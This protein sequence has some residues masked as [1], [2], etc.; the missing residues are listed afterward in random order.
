ME[1]I[2]LVLEGG[3]FRGLFVE[4][5]TQFLLEEKIFL[6]Y[7]IGVSMGATN[8]FNYISQQKGRNLEIIKTFIHD[9]RYLS[10]RNLFKEGSLF[11]M[12]F[13]FNDI[14]YEHIKYDF[15]TYNSSDQELV[16]GAMNCITGQTSYFFKSK[17]QMDEMLLALRASISLPFVSKMVYHNN[18]PHLD[19]GLTDPIPVEKAFNDGCTKVIVISTRDA[20]YEKA[21]FKGDLFSK[22]FY[23]DYPEVTYALNHRPVIYN[24]TQKKLLELERTGKL[25]MIRPNKPLQVGRTEKNLNKIQ[26]VYNQGYKTATSLKNEILNFIQK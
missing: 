22:Y 23:K 2:G 17:C 19:G 6:P 25:L 15:E 14:T 1:K 26:E 20:H 11:G 24:Q 12:D 16:I 7:V 13:I 8:G 5:V 4:G 3:G 18:I 10:K 21:S 9:P